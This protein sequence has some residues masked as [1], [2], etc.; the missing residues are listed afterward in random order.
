MDRAT[1]SNRD[2]SIGRVEPSFPTHLPFYIHMRVSSR[3]GS[4]ESKLF[5]LF[6]G[7]AI[8]I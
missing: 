8:K 3:A 5:L 4:F 6:K 2:N 7:T 1:G